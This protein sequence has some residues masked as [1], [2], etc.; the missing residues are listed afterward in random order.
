MKK[1]VTP[2]KGR[3]QFGPSLTVPNQSMP[4]REIVQRYAQGLPVSVN[5]NKMVFTEDEV[6]NQHETMDIE[7]MTEIMLRGHEAKQEIERIRQEAKNKKFE[8]G[9]RE[10]IAKEQAENE[11]K[12]EEKIRAKIAAEKSTIQS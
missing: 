8:L 5:R 6:A 4:I 10:K 7:E 11:A 9:L 1:F 2:Y 3:T 12:A